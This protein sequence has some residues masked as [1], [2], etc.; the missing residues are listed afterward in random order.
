MCFSVA[1]AK[2]PVLKCYAKRIRVGTTVG[3]IRSEILRKKVLVKT[4]F[5]KIRTGT[6]QRFTRE[7]GR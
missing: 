2:R 3:K 5:G 7:N 4:L 6:T 1:I